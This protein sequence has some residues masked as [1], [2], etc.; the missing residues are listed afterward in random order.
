VT[1]LRRLKDS[2][3]ASLKPDPLSK[4]YRC[5]RCTAETGAPYGDLVQI[6]PAC[7]EKAG[8]VAV[9]LRWLACRRCG[10]RKFRLEML[11]PE[12]SS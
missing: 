7:H 5:A 9:A 12:Q 1:R 6:Y 10:E 4:P 2:E 8:R 11:V 3:T